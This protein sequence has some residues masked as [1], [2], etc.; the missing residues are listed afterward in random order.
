MIHCYRRCEVS[1]KQSKRRAKANA[2]TDKKVPYNYQNKRGGTPSG[3]A[4]ATPV[5][6]RH[7]MPP[8]APIV[9]PPTSIMSIQGEFNGAYSPY[10]SAVST[11]IMGRFSEDNDFYNSSRY[12][13]VVSDMS[14]GSS[15][16]DI[17]M[18]SDVDQ[19]KLEPDALACLDILAKVASTSLMMAT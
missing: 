17:T 7:S 12:G 3:A 5:S 19:I 8:L 9:V 15:P 4:K 14:G 11:P 1:R 16:H 2:S 18:F 10:Y 6:G 13:D